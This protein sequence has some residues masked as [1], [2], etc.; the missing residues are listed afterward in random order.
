MKQLTLEST[1]QRNKNI[2]VAQV[3]SDVSMLD[4]DSGMYYI[5][6]NVAARIWELMEEKISLASIVSTL[7]LE[8]DVERDTCQKEVLAFAKK[9]I[10]S[11]MIS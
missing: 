7:V 2:A 8:Y 5:L 10:D 9:M 1:F 4:E 6:E 3:G 11:K